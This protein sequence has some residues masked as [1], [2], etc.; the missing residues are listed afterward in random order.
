M[1]RKPNWLK[2]PIPQGKNYFKLSKYLKNHHL[3][4]VCKEAKCPNIA[5][6]WAHGTATFMILGDKCTRSCKFC[7]VKNG[8]PDPIDHD[9]PKRL[10]ESVKLMKINHVVITSVTRDDLN[11]CGANHFANI[12]GL[13]KN[14]L[15]KVSVEVLIP[16]MLGKNELIDIILNANPDIINHNLETVRRLTPKIRSNADYDR[17]LGS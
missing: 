2:T 1:N 9:E 5:E 3:N 7:S 17:S 13:F 12:I 4:T 15:P 14:E 11:E 8:S 16:D 6:C 10:L